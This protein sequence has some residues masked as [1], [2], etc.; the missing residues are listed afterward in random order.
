[1]AKVPLVTKNKEKKI[2]N[3]TSFLQINIFLTIWKQQY[4]SQNYHRTTQHN[5]YTP[6]IVIKYEQTIACIMKS[7]M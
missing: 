1:M 4:L 3:K 2:E 5:L 6:E 7:S